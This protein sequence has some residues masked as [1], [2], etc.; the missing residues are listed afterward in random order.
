MLMPFEN[1]LALIEATTP[2]LVLELADMIAGRV[3]FVVG[4]EAAFKA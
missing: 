2:R 4:Q 3:G 1:A